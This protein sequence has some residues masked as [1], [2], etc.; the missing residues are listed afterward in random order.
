MVNNGYLELGYEYVII[1]DCWH[2]TNRDMFNRLQPDHIRFPSGIRALADYIHK[3]GLKFGIYTDYGTHTCAGFPG[4][5]DHLALDAATFAEWTVDYLKVD[6][7]YSSLE[8]M[9]YGYPQFSYYLNTT[10]RPIVLSCSW[11]A[12]QLSNGIQPDY[13]SI[14][15]Y[16]N[17]WRNFGDINNKIE[18]IIS[19]GELFAVN[20]NKFSLTHKPGSWNDPDQLV[21][22]NPGLSLEDSKLQM[23]LWSIL[24]A[25]LI[26]SADIR[27]IKPEFRKI[28][29]NSN[30]IAINQDPL[31]IMGRRIL[32][33][34]TYIDVW[35]KPL[36]FNKT[37]LVM[38][39]QNSVNSVQATVSLKE[40]G[41][42]KFPLYKI[43]DSFTSELIDVFKRE[44]AIKL[45]LAPYTV[46]A[47][48][49]EP[50]Q[51]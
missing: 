23:A 46:S 50:I 29:Q 48:W 36:I 30:L 7:C 11:P 41:L 32:T 14:S 42:D 31:G 33:A 34:A 17:L 3:R 49:A 5:I 10:N 27:T 16:C 6:G 43:F 37:A 13:F 12:Y 40:L 18:T 24:A 20:Q 44:N 28:L 51:L 2:A 9:N 22:G 39:N 19:I 35:T 21:V 26:M 4:S 47:L 25:P 38:L 1:D 45:T 8:S 15:K